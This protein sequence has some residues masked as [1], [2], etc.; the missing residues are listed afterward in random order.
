MCEFITQE[1]YSKFYI[2]MIDSHHRMI[3]WLIYKLDY[4]FKMKMIVVHLNFI[5]SIHVCF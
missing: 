3:K 1:L 2:N 5:I 4:E